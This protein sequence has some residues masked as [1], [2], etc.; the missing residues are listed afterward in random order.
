MPSV[1]D[2]TYVPVLLLG[3]NDRPQSD[4]FLTDAS[5]FSLKNVTLGY[6]VAQKALKKIGIDQL[7]IFATGD[8]LY[9]LSARKGMDPQYNF[10]G[11]QDYVYSPSRNITFGV[12]L[13][14]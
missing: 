12:D 9:L 10:T 2:V 1:G 5:Y 13:K 8:N 11:T 3:N 6:T 7:R 4:R 14:F